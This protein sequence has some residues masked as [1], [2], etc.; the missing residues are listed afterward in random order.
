V[1]VNKSLFIPSFEINWWFLVQGGLL[2]KLSTAKKWTEQLGVV[3][4]AGGI[5][6]GEACEPKFSLSRSWSMMDL[7]I[8]LKD[9]FTETSHG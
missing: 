5:A 4:I 6:L 9:L 7:R 1:T 8:C 3:R 2:W